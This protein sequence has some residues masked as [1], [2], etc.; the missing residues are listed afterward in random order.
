M[1]LLMPRVVFTLAMGLG[2]SA[3]QPDAPPVDKPVEPQVSALSAAMQEPLARAAAV[4]DELA[5]AAERQKAAIEAA[6]Q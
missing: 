3:C 1:K 4:E 5:Q 6:A 2:L